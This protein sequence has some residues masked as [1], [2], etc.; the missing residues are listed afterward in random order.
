MMQKHTNNYILKGIFLGFILVPI[1][2]SFMFTSR[3]GETGA[4][5][6][7]FFLWDIFQRGGFWADLSHDGTFYGIALREVGGTAFLQGLFCLVADAALICIAIDEKD[8]RLIPFTVLYSILT[9]FLLSAVCGDY[10]ISAS[11]HSGYNR[12]M[13]WGCE[14]RALHGLL[15]VLMYSAVMCSYVFYLV[16]DKRK[17]FKQFQY[18]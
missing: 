18:S 3:I 11:L 17:Q 10:I 15:P 14:V 8:K 1:L 16:A 12:L 9:L 4:R 13:L 6:M 7:K 2:L 5:D